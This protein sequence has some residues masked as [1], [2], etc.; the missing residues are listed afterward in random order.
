MSTAKPFST[1]MAR[2]AR[3]SERFVTMP[4]ASAKPT[5]KSVKSAGVAIITV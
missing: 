3:I 4:S 2:T 1:G 5:P